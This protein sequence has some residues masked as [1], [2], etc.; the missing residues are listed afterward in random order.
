[1][2]GLIGAI[3]IAQ[4]GVQAFEQGIATVSQN[5][6]NQTTVGYAVQSVATTT[7]VNHTPGSPGNGVQSAISRAA[8][9]FAA[10]VLRNAT[11]AAQAASVS[12]TA[13]T[14]ISNAV[15]NNGNVQS[16]INQFFLDMSTLAGSPTSAAQRQTVL[17][18]AQTVSG[19]FQSAT[20]SIQTVQ[21]GAVTALQ[22]N[23]SQVNG[24]LA[25]LAS[26]N[27]GLVTSPNNP[28]LLDQQEAAL[29]SLSNLLPV[30]V[31]SLGGSGQVMV[32]AGGTVL[33]NQAGAQSLT[34]NAGTPSTAPSIT[35][36]TGKSPLTVEAEDGQ[37][38]ANL[39]AWQSGAAAQQSLNGLAVVFAS[40][41]NTAQ[42]QG[43]T[44]SGAQGAAL[45]SI[46]APSVTAA[47]S[48]GGTA[49]VTAQISDPASLPADGG[50]FTLTYSSSGGWT[51]LDQASQQ[52][53]TLGTGSSLSFAGMTLSVSGAPANGDSFQ[54]D[55]APAAASAISVATADVNA[56]A[57]ADPYV[58]TPGQLQANGT[59]V[60][61]NGGTLSTGSSSV[62]A[63]P[64]SG[65][66]TIP[67]SYF[68]QSLQLVFTS[69]TNFNVTTTADP[70]TVITSGSLSGT[71]PTTTLAI[72][73]PST[74]AAAGTYWQ[75]PVSGSPVAGDV[76]TL[77]TGGSGSGSNATR[78][79]SLWTAGQGTSQGS[80]QQAF[81]NL[82]S[83]LGTQANQATQ[84]KAATT[85]QVT[86]ATTNLQA[87][88]GV[89]LNQQA[90]LLTQYQQAFQAS[91]QVIAS[92]RTMFQ[93]LLQAVQ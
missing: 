2:S 60:N 85:A 16:R 17:S 21:S 52:S 24:L 69:A 78:M 71:N 47:V 63:S 51:A 90:V 70:S 48:N 64:A 82:T 45:F 41:V 88:A 9:A 12:S 32:A 22:G 81:V 86:T 27:K 66:T 87:V 62:T 26:I 4:T 44:P 28:G 56:I 89:D 29:G 67:A 79:Q 37:I 34:L 18:D 73:Y 53:Y 93:S 36:G 8:D 15:T 54:L 25:Q 50:P 7:L 65:A 19:A 68:G 20:A 13:L 14:N 59:V 33:L 11:S 40:E 31:V 58:G 10:G 5:V 61:S 91:A 72:A 1:M 23:V 43:L 39:A 3:D 42:A 92:V 84:I 74:S 57:A 49:A 6:A 30:N 83:D 77:T 80:M 75:L 76:L 55:P 46:P 35:V 38:G